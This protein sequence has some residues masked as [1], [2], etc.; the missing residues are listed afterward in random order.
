MKKFSIFSLLL[1]ACTLF[2]SVEHV[3]TKEL[4]KMIQTDP[5]LVI[6]DARL[7]EHFSGEVIKGAKWLPYDAPDNVIIKTLPFKGSTI[8]TYC[9]SPSCPASGRLADRLIEMGYENVYEYSPGLKEWRAKELPT[10]SY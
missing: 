2:A 6:I 5:T 3:S 9:L 1:I 4:Q 7:P 8:V 10:T